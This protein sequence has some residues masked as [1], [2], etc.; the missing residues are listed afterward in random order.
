ML[1]YTPEVLYSFLAQYNAALWPWQA[2]AAALALTAVVLALRG[3]AAGGR[4]I[5]ALLAAG[6]LWCGAV[7]H[8]QHFETINIFAQYFAPVFLLQALLLLWT[9]VLR[10]HL[11]FNLRPDIL[12]G[13]AVV[14]ILTAFI[15]T[16]LLGWFGGYNIDG[17][18]VVGLTPAP[19]LL[20]TLA[21]LLIAEGRTP[22]HLL[23]LPLVAVGIGAA[24]A[25]LLRLPWEA[26]PPLLGLLGLAAIL[27]KN[28]R[29]RQPAAS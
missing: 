11:V 1:P 29:A 23:F 10:G 27:A 4:A 14:L 22:L 18:A 25:W 7:F 15:L 3:G 9:G 12:G 13:F 2:L 21:L 24:E 26:L 8:L 5:S 20:F 16:P 19:T 17:A 6:W 28:R